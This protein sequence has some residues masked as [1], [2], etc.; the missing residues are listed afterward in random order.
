MPLTEGLLS[1][2][3]L[4]LD[5][6]LLLL[7]EEGLRLLVDGLLLVEGSVASSMKSSMSLILQ[8]L[9]QPGSYNS[10]RSAA[11]A[12]GSGSGSLN[13]PCLP[14]LPA[15]SEIDSTCPR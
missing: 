15:M 10:Q 1:E 12:G 9:S 8:V 6:S 14:G 5:E 4:S 7:T 3:R 11:L 2:L 13:R